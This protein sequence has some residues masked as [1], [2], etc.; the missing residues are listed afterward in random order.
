MICAIYCRLSKEDDDRALESESIQNQKAILLS[1][2]S[3]Q[4][5]RIH[6]IYSDEDYSGADRERPQWNAMLRDAREGCFQIILCKTQSRF[7]RDLEIVERYIHGFF[8]IWGIRFVALLDNIDTEQRGN[9]KARQ[10][11]GLINEWYLEDLSEN[12][13][14]VLREKRRAGKYIGSFA[15][16]GYRKDPLNHNRLEPDGPAAAVVRNIFRMYLSGLGKA[17]IAVRLNEV[18]IPSPSIYRGQN[19]ECIC[20]EVGAQPKWSA[21]TVGRILN[22]EVYLGHTVQ[23][24]R[25]KVSYKSKKLKPVPKSEWIRVED[26]HAPLIDKDSFLAVGSMLVLRTRS[27]GHGKPHPLAGRVFCADCGAPMVKISYRYKGELR[28]YLQCG[29]YA[30]N[31]R[32]PVCS[33]HSV[34]LDRLNESLLERIRAHV[35]NRFAPKKIDHYLPFPL[36]GETMGEQK[37]IAMLK[38]RILRMSAAMKSLYLDRADGTITKEKYLEMS[39]TFRQDKEMLELQ[40]KILT[41]Q[42]NEPEAVAETESLTVRLGELLRFDSLDR[43]ICSNLIQDV[44]V[45]EKDPGALVQTVCVRWRF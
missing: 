11:N 23:G 17:S 4:G 14:A 34:R 42:E 21:S 7:T 8:P 36:Y 27:D 32:A 35:A 10:I 39:E 2:A 20:G 15:P 5:W 43:L 22:G 12:I 25:Q 33:R 9:K 1:H 31:R 3:A 37:E 28:A 38:S 26:T 19:N 29:A 18:G 45:G 24:V 13:R 40:L 6:Q 16:Y 30:K 41:P 44:R